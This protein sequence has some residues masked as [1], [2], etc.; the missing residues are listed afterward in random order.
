[1]Q[2]VAIFVVLAVTIFHVIP[3]FSVVKR[4]KI[5]GISSFSAVRYVRKVAHLRLRSRGF[6]TALFAIATRTSGMTCLEFAI[7]C[8]PL[9]EKNQASIFQEGNSS[10]FRRSRREVTRF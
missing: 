2:V 10:A 3:E 7:C 5:S 8:T 4:R 1:M 9:R 6:R